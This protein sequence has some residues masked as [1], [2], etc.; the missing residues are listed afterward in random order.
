MPFTPYGNA[1]PGDYPALFTGASEAR[2]PKGMRLIYGFAVLN[3]DHRTPQ[4][5]PDGGGL[6]AVAVCN[7]SP[8]TNP[9]SKPFLIRKAML[10]PEEFEDPELSI[11]PPPAEHFVGRFGDRLRVLDVRVT[12]RETDGHQV[13]VVTHICRPRDGE[14]QCIEGAYEGGARGLRNGRPFWLQEDGRAIAYPEYENQLQRH[15]D[16]GRLLIEDVNVWR[17]WAQI[18][19]EWYERWINPDGSL[20]ELPPEEIEGL[21]LQMSAVYRMAQYRA[22]FGWL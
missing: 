22:R 19:R 6:Y 3:A 7:M 12:R 10:Q 8:G 14:W 1:E 20:R 15:I 16:S 9:K 5:G 4:D 13:S 11:C 17:L 2:Y 21:G 18:G